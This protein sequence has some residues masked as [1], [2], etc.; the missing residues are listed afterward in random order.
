MIVWRD[1]ALCS[2]ESRLAAAEVDLEVTGQRR[3]ELQE[4][5][6]SP[7]RPSIAAGLTDKEERQPEYAAACRSLP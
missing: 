6:A 1:R 7:A 2:Q 5:R 4:G 3:R